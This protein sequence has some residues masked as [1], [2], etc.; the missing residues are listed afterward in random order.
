MTTRTKAI[1]EDGILKPFGK[2]ELKEGEEVEIVIAGSLAKDFRG[3]L[4][5]ENVELIE[6]IAESDELI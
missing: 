6:E 2:L 4:K 3:A 5:L 1:Y